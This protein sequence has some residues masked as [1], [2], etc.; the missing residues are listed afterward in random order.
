M[1][2]DGGETVLQTEAAVP[3][4][5][6]RLYVELLAKYETQEALVAE[7]C[8]AQSGQGLRKAPLNNSAYAFM[9]GLQYKARSQ[10]AQ[11]EAFRTGQKYV[12]MKAEHKAQIS[13][14]DR[15]IRRLKEEVAAAHRQAVTQRHAWWQAFDDAEKEHAN[16]LEKKDRE[17]KKMEGRALRA[18][19]E[20][21]EWRDRHKEKAQELY[22]VQTELGEEQGKNHKLVAQIN[23]DHENSSLPSSQKPNRKKI[24]NNRE[25]TGRKRGGQPGHKGHPRKKHKPTNRIEIPAPEEYAGSPDYVPTRKTVTKQL[26]DI[27]LQVVV[28]EYYTQEFRHVRTRQR[29]HADF[30]EGLHNE[31]SYSGNVK[32]FAFLLNNRCNVSL[33][34][35]SDFLAELTDGELRVSTGMINGLSKEFSRKTEAERKK[36]YADILLSP[37][38][39]T[40]FSTVKVNGASRQVIVCATPSHVLYFAKAHKGHEGVK[41]TPV[42]EYQHTIVSDNDKTF[43]NYG[44]AWQKCLEHV[45]RY[46]KG[47]MENEPKLKWNLQM[48]GLIREMIHFRKHLDPEDERDPDKIAPDKVAAFEHR[49]DEILALAKDEYA[50]EPPSK[51]YVDGFNLHKRLA[52]YKESH[53][54]FLH[55]KSVPWTNN[56]SERLLRV[57]KRK[58][59]QVM[60]F[61]SDEGV[62]NLC[63][64]LGVIATLCAQGNNLYGDVASVF[65]RTT[66]GR[67]ASG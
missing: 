54:L 67:K 22:R 13:A 48:H 3:V 20:R 52:A 36:A 5:Y 59:K 18:E 42:E 43:D 50:Y 61:R 57:L 14:K 11:L 55:D 15:E 46:L 53:M 56:L 51:Y 44:N 34:K 45:L 35:V 21:D 16:E 37:V 17:L 62:D 7:L 10:A 63:D 66:A 6:E 2:V 33:A 30:P 23:R 60:T 39:C 47:S 40:D 64:S 58:F 28:T 12:D 41:G 65:D 19:R 29:V 9:T 38:M 24:A 8:G 25:K 31:V 49:Y 32:A 4:D 27:R 26:V 1:N